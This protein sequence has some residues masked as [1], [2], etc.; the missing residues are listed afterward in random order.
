[1]HELLWKVVPTPQQ[2]EQ[3]PNDSK[4]KTAASNTKP[5]PHAIAVYIQIT[6]L[7]ET[8]QNK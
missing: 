4:P 6:K 2:Q 8:P 7:K 1:M 3:V 5:V